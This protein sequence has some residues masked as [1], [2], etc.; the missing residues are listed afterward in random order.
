MI[1]KFGCFVFLIVFLE[2]EDYVP[3]MILKNCKNYLFEKV[4]ILFDRLYLICFQFPWKALIRKYFIR[5]KINKFLC[6]LNM[7]IQSQNLNLH[8][9][10]LSHLLFSSKFHYWLL[11]WLLWPSSKA[12]FRH[13]CQTFK[14]SLLARWQS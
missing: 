11:V 12:L 10:H 14:I 8:S 9:H 1:K 2:E 6:Y 3:G 7:I 4:L 13:C 5:I